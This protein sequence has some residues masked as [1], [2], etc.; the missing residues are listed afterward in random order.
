[1]SLSTA[2]AAYQARDVNNHLQYRACYSLQGHWVTP[3]SSLNINFYLLPAASCLVTVAV[4][5]L[6]HFTPHY[7]SCQNT[8]DQVGRS[9][10]K[11]QEETLWTTAGSC[12]VSSPDIGDV[13]LKVGGTSRPCLT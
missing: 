2:W 10:V 1:M 8:A 12:I 3:Q 13:A 6:K 5:V 11:L 7:P 4:A 9:A